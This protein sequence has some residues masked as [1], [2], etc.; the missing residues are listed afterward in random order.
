MRKNRRRKLLT[1]FLCWVLCIANVIPT[2]MTVWASEALVENEPAEEEETESD[3]VDSEDGGQESADSDDGDESEENAGSEEDDGD[4]QEPENPETPEEEEGD[5]PEE[6]E[7]DMETEAPEENP[8]E[9]EADG[10][11]DEEEESLLSPMADL[12][13]DTIPADAI[14]SGSYS[15][16]TWYIDKNGKLVVEGTGNFRDSYS[17]YSPW[18][19]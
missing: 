3:S 4:S 11:I 9:A 2:G 5:V 12:N 18:Y 8:E 13:A 17:S 19:Q 6:P 15:D 14:A 1:L 7:E 10:E 16:I